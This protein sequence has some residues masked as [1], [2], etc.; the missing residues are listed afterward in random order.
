MRELDEVMQFLFE[1]L[2]ANAA[3]G[4]NSV[5]TIHVTPYGKRDQTRDIVRTLTEDDVL[6]AHT[7]LEAFDGNFR[8]V[9]GK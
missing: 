1:A 9:F 7:A 8:K 6:E 2:S 3:R 5:V 4:Q